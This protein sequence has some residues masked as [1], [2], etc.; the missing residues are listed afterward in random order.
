[1]AGKNAQKRYHADAIRAANM[2]REGATTREIADALGKEP[3][4]IK[5]IVLLGERLLPTTNQEPTK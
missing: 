5:A 2:A 4:R 3:E 1:M